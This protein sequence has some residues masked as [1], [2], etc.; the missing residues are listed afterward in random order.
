MLMMSI[1][2]YDDPDV[3]IFGR[4]YGHENLVDIMFHTAEVDSVI[5]CLKETD[6]CWCD[7]RGVL[8]TQGVRQIGIEERME[9]VM[10][11]ATLLLQ[12]SCSEDEEVVAFVT[13]VQ[14]VQTL[15]ESVRNQL[16]EATGIRGETDRYERAVIQWRSGVEGQAAGM[17][18]FDAVKA[19]VRRLEGSR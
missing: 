10:R 15:V 7:R 5:E 2:D 1:E 16:I 3:Q 11:I 19:E 4:L 18:R 6:S 12:H 9:K 13:R 17:N 14:R 8:C